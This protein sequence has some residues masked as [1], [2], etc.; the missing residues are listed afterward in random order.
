MHRNGFAHRRTT[1]KKKKNL[2]A[3]DSIDAITKFFLETRIFQ[4]GV[5]DLPFSQVFNRDQVPIA[6]ANAYAITVDEKNQ[7]V[8]ARDV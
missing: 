5:P 1:T 7:D 6:L 8:I 3:P 2:S 4:L